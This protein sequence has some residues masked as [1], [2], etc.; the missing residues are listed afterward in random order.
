M[1]NSDSMKS[2]LSCVCALAIAFAAKADARK[3]AASEDVQEDE[4]AHYGHDAGGMRYS[5]LSQINRENVSSLKVA[6][7]FHTGDVS[8][9]RGDRKRSGFE[10]TPLLVQGTW[11]PTQ[12]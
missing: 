11:H 2:W 10:S 3:M 8:D 12:P 9:G 4:W 6:W 7:T 5:P 1:K